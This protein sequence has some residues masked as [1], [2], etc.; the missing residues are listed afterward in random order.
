M[1]RRVSSA[2]LAAHA[3][4]ESC[5]IVIHG[6]VYDV[7]DFHHPGGND[8]LFERGGRDASAA[9]DA[10]GHSMH[11]TKH[12]QALRV[13]QLAPS[14]DAAAAS[15]SHLP[16]APAAPRLT[17]ADLPAAASASLDRAEGGGIAASSGRPP[18]TVPPARPALTSLR[19]GA[20]ELAGAASGGGIRAGGGGVGSGANSV[21][22][23]FPGGGGSLEPDSQ[24][25]VLKSAVFHRAPRPQDRVWS[26]R[27]RGFLPARN[28]PEEVPQPYK[29]LT[30]LVEGLPAALA[31]G[32]FR[33]LVDARAAD[34]AP[35]EAAIRA[36]R[37]EALLERIHSLYGYIGKGCALEPPTHPPTHPPPPHPPHTHTAFFL[38]RHP[39]SSSQVRPRAPREQR[40]PPL[41]LGRTALPAAARPRGDGARIARRR[42]A[43]RAHTPTLLGSFPP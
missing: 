40:A 42:P 31:E 3:T 34:F 14:P 5:W 10:I 35:L 8:R 25:W 20:A 41:R 27:C 19:V 21:D 28:P 38:S 7:T 12:M 11:A 29:L 39:L 18:P 33:R 2:E 13:G 16:P 23:A 32:S 22:G 1:S 4:N 26:T 15:T 17:H 24:R 37:D 30:E 9:F 36:E 6:D 43:G